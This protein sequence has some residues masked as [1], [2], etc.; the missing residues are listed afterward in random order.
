MLEIKE[1]RLRSARA[2]WCYSGSK[3]SGQEKRSLSSILDELTGL[4]YRKPISQAC[5]NSITKYNHIWI[6]VCYQLLATVP[7][8]IRQDTCWFGQEPEPT[9]S[10]CHNMTY[11]H[12]FVNFIIDAVYNFPNWLRIVSA[13][14]RSA[15]TIYRDSYSIPVSPR[16]HKVNCV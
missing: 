1:F 13:D 10:K 15:L 16:W 6:L 8:L 5:I 12:A 2:D 3:F 11:T 14:P 9:A 7:L 4:S